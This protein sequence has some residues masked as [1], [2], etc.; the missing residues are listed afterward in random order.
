MHK[1]I[2]IYSKMQSTLFP[3]P[4]VINQ[5]VSKFFEDKEKKADLTKYANSVEKKQVPPPKP[6]DP[7][8]IYGTYYVAIQKEH[9]RKIR[10]EEERE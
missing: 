3:N 1:G 5:R 9:E 8:T 2:V 7:A 6:R 10:E 4:A